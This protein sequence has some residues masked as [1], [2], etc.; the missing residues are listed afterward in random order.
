MLRGSKSEKPGLHFCWSGLPLDASIFRLWRWSY[1]PPGPCLRS[2][3]QP[4]PN[5]LGFAVQAMD[6]CDLAVER[7]D[8]PWPDDKSRPVTG[9]CID[10]VLF[11]I[12]VLSLK[13][14]VAGEGIE[15]S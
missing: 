5:G 12:A 15:P 14:L 2:F 9:C 10:I 3:S 8:A 11:V 7:M 13:K 1:P 6:S 4:Y